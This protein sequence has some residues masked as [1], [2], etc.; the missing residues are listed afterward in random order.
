MSDSASSGSFAA[1]L[2]V[3]ARRSQL[4]ASSTG[5]FWRSNSPRCS[6]RTKIRCPLLDRVMGRRH[7]FSERAEGYE[8]DRDVISGSAIA[9]SEPERRQFLRA[10]GRFELT[11]DQATRLY[12]VEEAG[13]AGQDSAMTQSSTTPISFTRRPDLKGPD[14]HLDHRPWSISVSSRPRASSPTEPS[15]VDDP[16]DAR[17]VRA[18]RSPR[19]RPLQPKA[20]ASATVV[21][22]PRDSRIPARSAL[23]G[24][25]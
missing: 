10:A 2:P 24:R 23:P 18:S 14:Q 12:I 17:R 15:R 9:R 13:S 7:H 16:T 11:R 5:T 6:T 25:R 3:W 20:H 1:R 8:S 22:C 19:S 4:L 21:R